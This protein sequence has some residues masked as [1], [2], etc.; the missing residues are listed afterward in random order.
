MKK[1][2]TLAEV[3]ITLG[4]IGV[5]AA[6]AAPALNSAIQKSKVG[7]SLRKFV[8]NL[9]N[10]NEL[11]LQDNDADKL[12]DITNSVESYAQLIKK[13]LK[14]GI[15]TDSSGNPKNYGSIGPAPKSF[16][17]KKYLS[18]SQF[19]HVYSLPDGTDFALYKYSRPG[20]VPVNSSYKG[21]I[22]LAMFDINGFAQGPNRMG[23]DM[24]EFFIDDGGAVV[25]WG[26]RQQAQ[27]DIYWNA[28]E[29]LDW[30][31]ECAENKAPAGTIPGEACAGSIADHG[32][33]VVYKY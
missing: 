27:E 33:K 2:F 29:K 28:K 7:P 15:V 20:D 31:T 30:E 11:I 26:G 17:G 22:F 23:K 4:I 18:G 21:R 9:E 12:T 19:T 8:S 6:L 3:L 24:F 32:W 5:V 1:G 16:D 13:Q 25:P 14:G 10:A